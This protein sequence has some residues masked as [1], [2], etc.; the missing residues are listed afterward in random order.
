MK[1]F[2]AH[3]RWVLSHLG[4]GSNKVGINMMVCEGFWITFQEY[5]EFTR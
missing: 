1:I 5:M 3:T 2:L 4:S